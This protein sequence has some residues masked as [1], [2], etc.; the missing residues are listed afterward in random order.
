MPIRLRTAAAATLVATAALTAP[1][2][3]AQRLTLREALAR[4]DDHAFPNR[5]AEGAAAAQRG[6]ATGALRGILPSLRLEG[7]F[8]RT[9][10][11]IG[12]FGTTLRQRAITQADFDPARLNRPAAI[13]NYMGGAVI[14]QPLFNADAWSGRRAASR[15]AAGAEASAHWTRLGTRVDVIRAFYGATLARERVTTLVAAARAFH[16][17]V[18]QAD[19]MVQQGLAT[20]SDAL[21]AAV[22][23]S[24][25]DAQLADAEAEARTAVRQLAVV[26]GE[27]SDFAPTLPERLPPAE[28]IRA[29]IAPD[30]AD[31]A[32]VARDDVEAARLGF[33]AAR[34][35]VR[36][37]RALYLPRLHGFARYEWNSA[38]TLYDGTPSWALG[39]TA[40]WSPFAGASE[41]AEL[42]G[43]SG[44]ADAASAIADAARERAD[45]EVEQTR[46][47]LRATLARLDIA[48]RSVEQSA[49]AHR[50]VARK[51]D[52]GLATVSE[53]LDAAAI[54]TRSALA[55]STARLAAITA[56]AERLRA[57]GRD[58]G[59]LARLDD[60]ATIALPSR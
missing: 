8:V 30:T 4:A 44:R 3:A 24:E 49:E 25:I 5:I 57:L 14:E 18:R 32:A 34:L 56:G 39:V 19:L 41:L 6:T 55:L 47:A 27:G 13:A 40:S 38:T 51:Y 42:Q 31:A 21:L 43:T 45:L 28:R 12:V 58:P 54:D 26:V 7:G 11:P 23:A 29:V 46:N 10:D 22:G 50:I 9:D 17:H 52:G 53:L 59:S 20:K 2:L 48:E 37:A 35:D 15:A 33:E 60:A 36:R 16:A 1:P